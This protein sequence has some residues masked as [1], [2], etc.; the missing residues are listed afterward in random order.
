MYLNVGR[1]GFYGRVDALVDHP[2]IKGHI[3]NPGGQSKADRNQN[4]QAAG[5]ISP[6]VSPG[7]CKYHIPFLKV[8]K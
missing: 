1:F 2:E 8:P 4:N 5:F 6:D 7:Y 3:E